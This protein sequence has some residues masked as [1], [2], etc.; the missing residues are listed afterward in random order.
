M[1]TGIV[2]AQGKVSANR[3]S[4]EIQTLGIK[5]PVVFSRLKIGSSLAVNGVCLTVVKK[6][7][8]NIFFNVVSETNRKSTLGSLKPGDPVNLERPLKSGS[9]IE[10]HWVL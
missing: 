5:V 3:K 6:R 10:G 9:R 8:Q 1:F 4:R 7:G 2:E